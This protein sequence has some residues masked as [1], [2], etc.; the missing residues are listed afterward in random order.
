MCLNVQLLSWY[1][2][3]FACMSAKNRDSCYFNIFSLFLLLF[4]NLTLFQSP[5]RHFSWRRYEESIHCGLC[6]IQQQLNQT[7]HSFTYTCRAGILYRPEGMLPQ[8][9]ASTPSGKVGGS[10]SLMQSVLRCNST[11]AQIESDPLIYFVHRSMSLLS[12]L[13]FFPS[14]FLRV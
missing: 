12:T 3:C 9:F 1:Y 10:S 13:L 14:T 2:F 4:V 6:D 8:S 11:P 5:A 7:I